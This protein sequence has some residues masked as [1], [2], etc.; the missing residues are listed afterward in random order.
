M[1]LKVVGVYLSFSSG[2]GA[3][4]AQSSSQWETRADTCMKKLQSSHWDYASLELI[5]KLTKLILPIFLSM[6]YVA[7]ATNRKQNTEL[8]MIIFVVNVIYGI[9]YKK[10]TKLY[11]AVSFQKFKIK[12]FG[13]GVHG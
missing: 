5:R 13:S 11:I 6:L 4:F 8:M 12:K 1:A 2:V 7:S 10:D 9:S 3:Q